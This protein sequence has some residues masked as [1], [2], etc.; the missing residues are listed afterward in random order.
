MLNHVQLRR[1]HGVPSI[2]FARRKEQRVFDVL[3]EGYVQSDNLLDFMYSPDPDK[4]KS[5]IYRCDMPFVLK[6]NSG[7]FEL[8]YTDKQMNYIKVEW[9]RVECEE[10]EEDDNIFSVPGWW[11]NSHTATCIPPVKGFSYMLKLVPFLRSGL[12]YVRECD[13]YRKPVKK[14][15]LI[16]DKTDF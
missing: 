15:K 7:T 8:H 14:A 5:R 10:K 4:P 9:D 1:L 13:K 6:N 12:C 16:A 11:E 3:P 2:P